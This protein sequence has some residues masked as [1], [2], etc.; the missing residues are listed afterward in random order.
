MRTRVWQWVGYESGRPLTIPTLFLDRV[1]G[2]V[3]VSKVKWIRLDK[4]DRVKVQHIYIY[5]SG[6]GLR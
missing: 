5:P 6:L 4:F 2:Q 1:S 3:G